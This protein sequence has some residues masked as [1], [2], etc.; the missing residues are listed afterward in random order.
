MSTKNLEVFNKIRD[1]RSGV[2]S[3]MA[4][5]GAVR[6]KILV[7]RQELQ[8]FLE[9]VTNKNG[10][11][12]KRKHVILQPFSRSQPSKS[13]EQMLKDMKRM[14]ILRSSRRMKGSCRI[15]WRPALESI[16]EDAGVINI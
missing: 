13:L 2:F 11:D 12:N 6:M 7:K 9:Q 5:N 8:Q 10:H 15:Y 1:H 14:R 4:E 16:P 3:Q